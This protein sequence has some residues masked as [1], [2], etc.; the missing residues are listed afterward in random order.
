VVAQLAQ[1]VI[2]RVERNARDGPAA[3]K[4]SSRVL[5]D[6]LALVERRLGE[7]H[8]STL[9][10]LVVIS[11][12]ERMLAHDGDQ[13]A[14][15]AAI[16]RAVAIYDRTGREREAVAGTLGLAVALSDAGQP[17]DALAAYRDAAGRAERLGDTA[18]VAQVQRNHGLLLA[19]LKRP[20]DAE[21]LL[22][23]AVDAARRLGDVEMLGRSLIALGIFL[24]HTGRPADAKPLLEEALAMMDPAHPDAIPARGHLGAIETGAACG[25]GDTGAAMAEAFRQFVLGR[26]PADLLE[27]L[28]VEF[29]DGDIKVGVHVSRKPTPEEMEKMKRVFDHAMAEFRKK[30]QS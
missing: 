3:L 22:R 8:P 23:S 17:D 18:L 11:N 19:E 20:A 28:D 14:R 30:V 12:V 1:E 4:R 6:V 10:V 13:K 29:K 21:P 16:R 9:N 27:R 26:L 7:D 2:G 15:A 24:Q 25:C 5:A